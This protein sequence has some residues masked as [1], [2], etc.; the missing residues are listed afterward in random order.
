MVKRLLVCGGRDVTDSG[1]VF[2]TLDGLWKT[3]DFDVVIEGDARGA[4]RLASAWAVRNRLTNLK[5][6]A[7]WGEYGKR[8]GPIRNQQMIEEGMPD[9]GVAFDG[10]IGTYDML[11]KLRASGIP[12]EHFISN[13]N[14]ID[15]V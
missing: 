1:W 14:R 2:S 13:P 7:K 5:F 6:P 4:D 8:A 3:Y 9:M 10:G 11:R 12:Y 15:V